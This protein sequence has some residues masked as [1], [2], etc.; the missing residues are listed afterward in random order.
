MTTSMNDSYQTDPERGEGQTSTD[1][2]K[3]IPHDPYAI[4]QLIT[5]SSDN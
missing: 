5:V 3:K 2:T 4:T 1:N